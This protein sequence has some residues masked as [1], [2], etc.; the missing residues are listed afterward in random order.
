SSVTLTATPAAGYHFVNWKQN[1]DAGGPQRI[2]GTTSPTFTFLVAYSAFLTA[3]FEANNPVL[4][5]GVTP[6]AS[7]TVTG[8][9]TYANGSTVTA[10]ATPAVG[11]AF[12][13][14]K[15]GATVISTSAS[16][17][18]TLSNH[19]AL[20]ANFVATNRTI[21]ATA[22][23]LASG[24]VTGAG[25]FGNGAS[26]TLTA[27]PASGY[28]FNNWT[29][30]GAAA[31]TENPAIFN[32]NANYAFVANF[33][34]LPVLSIAPPT[35]AGFNFSWPDTATGWVLQESP[36]LSPAGWINSTLP[37]TTSGGQNQVSVP[38]PT[39]SLFFR[40]AHP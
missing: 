7:G 25:V 6:A 33:T 29:L 8:A 17:T 31:G 39:G 22:A 10:N 1:A 26:V 34:A 9:G 5:L 4:T 36:D 3:N 38:S 30:G 14:W 35:G 11:Y 28:I 2:V 37:I 13:S 20:T 16:Y 12:A 19:T 23:P 27:T 24:S 32:A 40:L 15:S 18:M 21:T